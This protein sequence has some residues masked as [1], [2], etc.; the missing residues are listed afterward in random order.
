M[1]SNR[2]SKRDPEPDG[3]ASRSSALTLRRTIG[4]I[5]LLLL[6]AAIALL[7]YGVKGYFDARSDAPQLRARADHLIANKLGANGLGAGQLDQLLLVE[8]PAF[9]SHNGV[10]FETA[11][12][13]MT[14]ITQ[15]LAKRVAFERFRP[16]LRKIRLIGYANGLERSLSKAQILALF[17]DTAEM[18]RGPRGW[19]TGFY[20]AS[21]A[22]YGRPPAALERQEFLTLVAVMIAPSKYNLRRP[23]KPLRERVERIENLVLKRCQ[24]SGVRDVWLEGCSAAGGRR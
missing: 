16:G 10:D 1:E 8:D 7:G 14:T 19:M 23:D 5:A 15:S 17:L 9:R 3:A 12:A 4:L 21:H 13:G 20:K 22:V 2:R 11:G 6:L 24:P 18:G